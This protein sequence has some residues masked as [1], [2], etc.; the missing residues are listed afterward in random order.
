MKEDA[1]FWYETYECL[2]ADYTDLDFKYSSLMNSS[3]LNKNKKTPVF[4]K[5]EYSILPNEFIV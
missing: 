2:I 3:Q 4:P 5:D 1:V